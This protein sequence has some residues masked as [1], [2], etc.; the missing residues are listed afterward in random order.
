VA[1]N[2]R[3]AGWKRHLSA[4]V[5][6]GVA[7]L[8]SQAEGD[9]SLVAVGDRLLW[10]GVFRK[11]VG[12]F[13]LGGCLLRFRSEAKEQQ[14]HENAQISLHDFLLPTSSMLVPRSL[15]MAAAALRPGKP[16]MEPPGGVHAPV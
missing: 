14:Q 1:H 12:H 9:V 6:I 11:I 5:R 16:V 7:L 10:R 4:R 2:A 8:A 13:L 3:R 15:K